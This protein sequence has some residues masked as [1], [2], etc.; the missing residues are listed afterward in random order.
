MCANSSVRFSYFH[1]IS[2]LGQQRYWLA[3]GIKFYSSGVR[4]LKEFLCP[5]GDDLLR[6]ERWLGLSIIVYS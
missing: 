6:N 4:K 3:I 1:V 2:L 5:Q